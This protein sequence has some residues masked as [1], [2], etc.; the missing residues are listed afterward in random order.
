LRNATG[1]KARLGWVAPEMLKTLVL[2]KIAAER[3]SR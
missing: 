1:G 3:G 2:A